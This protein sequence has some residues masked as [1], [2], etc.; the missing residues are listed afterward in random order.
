LTRLTRPFVAALLPV[1]SEVFSSALH[2]SASTTAFTL[3]ELLTSMAILGVMMVVLFSVFDQINKAW[4]IGE[5]RVE[6]FTQARAALDFMSRELSQAIATNPI[7]FYGD[8]THVYFV[9]PVN[10]APTN[11]SDLCEV[12]YEF[13]QDV[14]VGSHNWT[15]QLVR[16]FVEP[17]SAANANLIYNPSMSLSSFGS[18]SPDEP[19][20]LATNSIVNMGFQYGTISGNALTFSPTWAT[21]NKLPY[22]IIISMDV[23]D[24]RTAA[25]LRLVP[26]TGPPSW[27]NITSSTLRSFTTTV[28]L[29]NT[30]P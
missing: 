12:G 8:A 29:P 3:I 26:Y 6:T 13:D 7:T 17:S 20:A 16:H 9:A 30:L 25:K 28:Y 18:S 21:P 2:R 10:T 23:V 22:A 4:L 19:A 24:S 1:L 15:F 5:N 11:V 14:P 27:T